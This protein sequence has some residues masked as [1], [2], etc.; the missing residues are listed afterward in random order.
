M[1]K[2]MDAQYEKM[3]VAARLRAVEIQARGI[4]LAMPGLRCS[5]SKPIWPNTGYH[6]RTLKN[7]FIEWYYS[8]VKGQL[9][10]HLNS[11]DSKDRQIRPNQIFAIT[12]PDLP[13]I[14]PLLP[15]EYQ[16]RISNAVLQKLTYRYGVASLWQEEDDFHP[17]HHYESLYPQDA[18]YHNGVVWTWLAGP[19]INI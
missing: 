2:R 4:P 9:Y 12:A 5:P 10:D 11:D 16:I 14:E 3:L 19:V 18:A 15:P 7:N 13:G 6:R 1:P 8:P 17:W